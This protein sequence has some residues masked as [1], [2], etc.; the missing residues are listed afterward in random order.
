MRPDTKIVVNELLRRV[1]PLRDAFL[2]VDAFG[3]DERRGDNARALRE[4]LRLLRRGGLLALFPSGEVA[5]YRPGDGVG[6]APWRNA[7]VALARTAGAPVVPV[8]FTAHNRAR[9]HAAGLVHPRLR[10][11]LLVRELLA[12]R[13]TT[14]AMRVGEA[15]APDE[16]AALG[17]DG[18]RTALVRA[19]TLELVGTSASRVRESGPS[20]VA[21]RQDPRQVFAEIDALPSARRL[22][23]QGRHL[24]VWTTASEAPHLM[25]EIGRLREIAFRAVGE[26]TGRAIDLDAFD[27][28]YRQLVVVDT[29]ARE[30]LGGYRLAF[31]DEVLGDRGPDG[32]YSATLFGIEPE[33]FRRMGP[34][35]EL[36]RSFVA[37][38]SQRT[39]S[40]LF[41]LWKGI[42]R[43]V[44]DDPRRRT[45][46]GPVSISAAYAPES[47]AA[48]VDHL[49]AHGHAHPWGSLVH[50]KVPFVSGSAGCDARDLDGLSR[51]IS[52]REPD[53]KGV[54]VLVRNYLRLGGKM[55]G[56]SVDPAFGHCIDGLVLVDLAAGDRRMIRR[57]LGDEA[58]ARVVEAARTA[59]ERQTGATAAV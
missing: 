3:R 47:R 25:R 24:V 46:F 33:L 10:T 30:V 57:C 36:G 40:A 13:G 26:G 5:S 34:A 8:G 11:L 9:F 54:P 43:L 59:A 44:A 48:L 58:S 20:P 50:A 21:R 4:A 56:F 12:K 18:A 15:V 41:L 32:L 7:A 51:W 28:H 14:V 17:D 55:L 2:F 31:T 38:E 52:S 35:I 45:L 6:E 16:L 29:E 27:R 39:T 23:E 53:G 22:V 37:P 19:R 49:R 1:E 42:G